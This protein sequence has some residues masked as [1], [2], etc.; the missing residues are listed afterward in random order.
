MPTQKSVL[1]EYRSRQASLVVVRDSVAASYSHRQRF[2][3][4]EEYF[5]F[6]DLTRRL[7]M[8]WLKFL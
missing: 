1:E 6:L 2:G 8:E 3:G 4:R 5:E 7:G